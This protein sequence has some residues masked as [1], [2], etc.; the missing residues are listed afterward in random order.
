MTSNINA[1]TKV[2]Y[3]ISIHMALL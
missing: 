3:F 1:M 2:I